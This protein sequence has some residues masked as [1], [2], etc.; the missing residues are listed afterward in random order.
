LREETVFVANPIRHFKTVEIKKAD[1]EI[2]TVPK[3]PKFMK[4]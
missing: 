2:L 4:K 1:S 3:T